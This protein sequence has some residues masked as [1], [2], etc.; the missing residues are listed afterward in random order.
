MKFITSQELKKLECAENVS[1]VLNG[2][3]GKD[4]SSYWYTVTDNG[5]EYDVYLTPDEQEKY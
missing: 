4:G 3:S 5:K 2:I 1:V